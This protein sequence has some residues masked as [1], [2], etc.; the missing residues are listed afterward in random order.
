MNQPHV[1]VC[2][3]VFTFLFARVEYVVFLLGG[4]VLVVVVCLVVYMHFTHIMCCYLMGWLVGGDMKCGFG[5]LLPPGVGRGVV[6]V[7]YY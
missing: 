1:V 6:V 5:L 3:F 2:L 4:G 7:I